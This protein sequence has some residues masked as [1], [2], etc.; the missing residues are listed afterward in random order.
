MNSRLRACRDVLGANSRSCEERLFSILIL[1]VEMLWQSEINSLRRCRLFR[2]MADFNE[3]MGAHHLY[4][5]WQSWCDNGALT[6]YCVELAYKKW[7]WA[8][9]KSLAFSLLILP[10]P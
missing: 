10:S 1:Y 5:I 9:K 8:Q 2:N 6:I 7:H 4:P 3:E